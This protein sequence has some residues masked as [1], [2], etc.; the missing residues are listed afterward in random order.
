M[1]LPSVVLSGG[2]ASKESV[3]DEGDLGVIPGS[4]RPPEEEMAA[5]SSVPA[6]RIPWTEGPGGCSSGL[7]KSRTRPS[8]E[9]HT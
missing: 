7:A 6:W 1:T 4:G 5:R 8:N 3:C 2:S 9:A